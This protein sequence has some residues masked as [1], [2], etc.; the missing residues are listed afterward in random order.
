MSTTT[1]VDPSVST[2]PLALD[3]TD[4]PGACNLCGHNCGLLFDVEGGRIKK[5]RPDDRH[6]RTEG[7][8]CN[9]AYSI[10]KY[11]DHAQRLERPL[12]RRED[13]TFEEI[14]W[15]TAVQEIAAKLTQLRSDHGPRSMAVFGLGGQANHLGALYLVNYLR[16]IGSDRWFCAWAQEKTQHNLLDQWMFDSPPM[17]WLHIDKPNTQYIVMIGTNPRISNNSTRAVDSFK[18]FE[19]DETKRIVVVDPRTTEMTG[20][21]DRHVR[22]QPGS[23]A[24]FLL[25]LAAAIVQ[26]NLVDEDFL[27]RRTE[28][29]DALASALSG[30]D[31]EEMARRCGI[32]SDDIRLTAREFPSARGAGFVY[33]LGL[34]QSWFSTLTA[35]LM[36][37]ILTVTGNLARTGGAVFH[38]TWIPPMRS[39][40][41]LDEPPRAVASG[42]QG[43]KAL[44]DFHMYSYNLAPEE[45]TADHPERIRALIVDN[46]NP[47]LSAADT[48]AWDEAREQL[49]LLVCVEVAMTETARKAD[50]VLP[51]AASQEKWETSIF[52]RRYPQV[53]VHLRPPVIPPRGESLPEPEIYARI[54]DAMELFE[55]APA[56]L[57]EL[58]EKALEPGGSG[59]FLMK[60]LELASQYG[61]ADPQPRL[62]HW[63]YT[64]LGDKL[65]ARALA[66][67][68]LL[69]HL[70]AM[71]R[72][73][74]V[75]RAFGPE[76]EGKDPF[77]LGAEA[78]RRM[79]EHTEGFV[80][81][82]IDPTDALDRNIGWED[83]RVRLAPEP[84]IEE[85]DRVLGNPPPSDPEYPFMLAGGTRS[86]WTANT[87][88]RDPSWRKG[89]GPHCAV[90]VS[91]E[92]A[93]RLGFET[94]DEVTVSSRR[95]GV[96]L[97][98]VID[99]KMLP[100]HISIPNGFGALYPADGSAD[101]ELAMSGVSVNVLTDAQ[102][103]D[104]FT[105]CPHHK[106]VRCRIDRADASLS[107]NS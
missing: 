51:S 3:A 78:F 47:W 14:S 6:A 13:G 103:R 1:P 102:D 81:A 2:S 98:L 106:Q 56:E 104:P 34:E 66:F 63:T 10:P 5:I 32:E 25:G 85:I 35:Y 45:I 57:V 94:G 97:P 18:A 75:V 41:R 27:A 61:E 29:F 65:P 26:E 22:I 49:E 8:V 71:Q 69:A 23:D 30:V 79:V 36:R 7:Y 55:S 99:K 93:G 31:I 12:R 96:R 107:S 95:G 59:P 77:S 73:A 58:A 37:V 19:S 92:D 70:N 11:I 101:G 62:G 72:S 16:Q 86:G 42:I 87:I 39:A 64:T 84:M 67:P 24:Y 90:S 28:G 80:L 53:D 43:I 4:V 82:E 20:R 15:D 68:W 91:A 21:A 89:R 40:D 48:H 44:S 83:G 76:W 74:E 9:K 105:G 38:E 46:A 50:Y 100:G 17:T 60:A 88:Q 54:I 33:D 52:P